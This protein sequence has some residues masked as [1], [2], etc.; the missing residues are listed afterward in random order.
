MSARAALLLAALALPSNIAAEQPHQM[1]GPALQLDEDG[2]TRWQPLAS[3]MRRFE[4]ALPQAG[5]RDAV[6]Y[7]DT[8]SLF[9]LGRVYE[10]PITWRPSDRPGVSAE[11]WGDRREIGL[12]W[13]ASEVLSLGVGVSEGSDGASAG[14]VRGA[15]ILSPETTRLTVA[16]LRLGAA[17]ALSLERTSLSL[18]EHSEGLLFASLS[19]DASGTLSASYGRRHW[20]VWPGVDVAWAAGFDRA[21]PFASLQFEAGAER[22]R[23]ALRATWR[24]GAG[25]ELGVSLTLEVTAGGYGGVTASATSLSQSRTA[26]AAT[27]LYTQRRAYLPTLWRQDVTVDALRKTLAAGDEPG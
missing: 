1:V 10:A 24:E 13:S 17:S 15:Y 12:T 2:V 23:S 19:N 20:G 3:G 25:F 4:L 22:L 26:L 27:S 18:D 16:S 5:V 8:N 21:E 9:Y 14:Y 7:E 6:N 11:L